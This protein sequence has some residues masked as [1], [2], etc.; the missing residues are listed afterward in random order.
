MAEPT[1]EIDVDDLQWELVEASAE[2]SKSPEA[3][4]GLEII[5]A[6]KE[7][8]NDIR[9][10]MGKLAKELSAAYLVTGSRVVVNEER[11]AMFDDD[12]H[13]LGAAPIK[14]EGGKLAQTQFIP[15]YYTL[16]QSVRLHV[17]LGKRS[18]EPEEPDEPDEP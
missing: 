13:E 5:G 17:N 7:E 10:T 1:D 14:R 2:P 4:M 6:R 12:E 16:A 3:G 9:V 18:E 15:S 11:I 8:E